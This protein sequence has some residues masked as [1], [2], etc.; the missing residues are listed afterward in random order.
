MLNIFQ[1]SAQSLEKK[2]GLRR[3]KGV[4]QE[5]KASGRETQD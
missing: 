2:D 1:K 3:H 4:L 5:A